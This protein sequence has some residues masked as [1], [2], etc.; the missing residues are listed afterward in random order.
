MTTVAL[1]GAS[2]N[3]GR[4]VLAQL[5]E[6]SLFNIKILL[7]NDE[8]SRDFKRILKRKYKNITV[9]NGNL[10]DEDA[11][12]KLVKDSDYVVNCAA[13]IPPKSDK[14]PDK[15]IECNYY[16]VDC[17]VKAIKKVAPKSKLIHISTVAV[18]GNRNHLHPWAR[19][20]DPLLPSPF[21][22]YALSKV[23]GERL[24]L[25][26]DLYRWVI[27]RQ[28]A[29]LHNKMLTDNLGDGLMY[30]TCL[31]SPLE[32]VSAKDSGLLIKNIILK[33][34]KNEVENFWKKVFNIGARDE[35]R[36]TG[37]DTFN[38]GF[39][40]I[41]GSSKSFL[42]PNWHATRNFHGVWFSDSDEL[43]NRFD[44]KKQTCSDFWKDF[45]KKH[46]IYKA[47]KIIP[48]FIIKGLLMK[49]LNNDTNAP[50]YW[51]KHF[52]IA[53][54][55]A[56]FGGKEPILKWSDFPMLNEGNTSLGNIDYNSIRD[57]SRVK[58]H[59]FILDHGFDEG[60]PVSLIDIEDLRK[61]ALF[62]GGKII[63]ETMTV[64]D[65]Y[66]PLEWECSEGHRF[67]LSPYSVLFA[68]HWCKECFKVG[69]NYDML[70]KDSPFMAQ[71]YYDSHEKDEDTLYYLKE[72]KAEYSVINP[73]ACIYL[74]SGTGNTE[75]VARAFAEELR[76]KG[77]S[78]DVKRIEDNVDIE[79]YDYVGIAYPIHAFTA[80]ENVLEFAS[81][82]P[83][84]PSK[85]FFIKTGGE[86]LFYNNYSSGRLK[87]ILE[88]K[89]YDVISD[90]FYVM[91]YNMLYRHTQ[92]M[93]DKMWFTAQRKVNKDVE[94]FVQGNYTTVKDESMVSFIFRNIE[95]PF[96]GINGK[97]FKVNREN[98][99]NC[100]ACV[101][102]CPRK[103]ISI[104]D[105]RFV[106]G[107]SCIGCVRCSFN[108][109]TN[110][111]N[112]GLINFWKVNGK[113]KFGELEPDAYEV[114]YLK[115]SYKRYFEK[116]K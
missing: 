27:L 46:Q 106:F 54:R 104:V 28:S 20:G 48:P 1:T 55:K 45:A 85:V 74:F 112:I 19:V 79:Y 33:D 71:V 94:E 2:G 26:S 29:M 78:C 8:K 108:C 23:F 16:G 10:A 88:Q 60:K 107:D 111:I 93:A 69:W 80:P 38:D 91:P 72:G 98:C 4:E 44:Y 92:S 22:E 97:A 9:I 95:Q 67:M 62:R 31:N 21:D 58:E 5:Y 90:Y 99:V 70:A 47:G 25:E 51:R 52:D 86:A 49:P 6:T 41:G 89:G 109:P 11:V 64:G 30:H 103:N 57:I 50:E 65:L 75:M 83:I 61:T 73:K 77:I 13:V 110:A 113:Y 105:G 63:S 43:D 42:N 84:H 34:S 116:N 96:M 100:G 87:E 115:K 81:R 15:A 39:A 56:Y 76:N 12:N 35:N 14:Y 66:T 17:L 40:I 68:G 37:I 102:G 24:V 114:K 101:A 7:L 32:W 36:V 53:R 59:G 3:M 18:Y 82:L